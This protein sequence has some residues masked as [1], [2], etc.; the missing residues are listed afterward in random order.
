MYIIYMLFNKF[1]KCMCVCVYI[2]TH[3]H[4]YIYTL[5]ATPTLYRETALS[6]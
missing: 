1:S 5:C 4:T 6:T 3:I 2:Y